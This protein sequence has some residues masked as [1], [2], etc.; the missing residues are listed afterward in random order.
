MTRTLLFTNIVNIKDPYLVK[1]AKSLWNIQN[2]SGPDSLKYI[3]GLAKGPTFDVASCQFAL[4]YFFKEGSKLDALLKNVD[5]IL[6]PGG[7]FIGTCFDGERVNEFLGDKDERSAMSPLDGTKKMWSIKKG[8]DKFSKKKF[9][10]SINVYI[11]SI[12]KEHEEY[13]VPYELLVARAKE[14]N[15]RPLTESE[16]KTLGFN[17]VSMGSFEDL[18][19]EMANDSDTEPSVKKALKMSTDEK[20]FSFLNMWFVFI[21]VFPGKSAKK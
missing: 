9:A 19:K 21:K 17:G 11:D 16:S 13:L 6:K 5:S 10:Q 1:V 12:N 15:L 8:Y 20:A 18:F 7:C 2:E 14:H 3:Q 4:H